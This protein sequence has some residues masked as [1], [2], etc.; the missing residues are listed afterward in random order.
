MAPDTLDRFLSKIAFSAGGCWEWLGSLTDRGYGRFHLGGKTLRAHRV[1]W[2]LFRGSIPDDLYVLHKCDN[3]R[4]VNTSHLFLGTHQ[5]NMDDRSEKGRVPERHGIKSGTAKLTDEDVLKI[6]E[7]SE[8]GVELS[9]L[10]GVSTSSIS[11]IRSE[12]TWAHI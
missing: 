5:D 10:F 2:E 3:P 12:K 8:T 4:C 7:S 6:R 9:R 11:L 1:S